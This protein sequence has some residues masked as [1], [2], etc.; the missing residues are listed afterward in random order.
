MKNRQITTLLLILIAVVFI[1]FFIGRFQQGFQLNL[2]GGNNLFAQL[3]F[4]LRI[5]RV[6]TALLVGSGLGLAGLV[7]QTIFRNPLADG[8]LLGV[9]QAAGFGAALG[10]LWQH[11]NPVW[12]QLFA[13]GFGILA[14]IISLVISE[15]TAGNKILSLILAG[16]AVSAVFSAGIGILKYLADPIDQLP[17]IVYWL[18]GSLAGSTWLVL[19]RTSVIIFPVIIFFWF[20]RW[21]LNLHSIDKEIAFSFGLQNKL[22]LWLNLLASVLLTS[23]IISIS[24]VVGWIGLIIPNYARMIAGS[25]TSK[26]IPVTILFGGIFTVVCD[27]LARAL[28]PGEIPLGIFTALLGSLMFIALLIRK[29]KIA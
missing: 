12:I 29:E 23:S 27:D 13:F 1:S 22:E 3:F 6:L 26:A 9:S 4:Q 25:D 11:G 28:L 2:F 8:S 18:L 16:I 15:K 17:T 20:Y 10:I 7:T 19:L 24:G 21:R 14:L 5:P